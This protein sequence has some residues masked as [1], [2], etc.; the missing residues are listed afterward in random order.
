MMEKMLTFE[1][2]I[3]ALDAGKGLYI[4]AP[5]ESLCHHLHGSVDREPMQEL[6][7][8]MAET[9]GWPVYICHGHSGDE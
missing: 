6:L 5:L 4:D 7:L 1:E 8:F 2:A 9:K 3:Q